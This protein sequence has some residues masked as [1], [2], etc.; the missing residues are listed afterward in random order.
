MKLVVGFRRVL[1]RVWWLGAGSGMGSLL[2]WWLGVGSDM[3]SLC[4][5]WLG[6]GSKVE[7][8]GWVCFAGVGVILA[9]GRKRKK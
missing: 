2:F 8:G 9:V 3:C 7:C 5:W 1:R 4:I 6:M